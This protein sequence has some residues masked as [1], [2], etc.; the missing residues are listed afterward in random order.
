MSITF[1]GTGTSQG[2]PVIG[3]DCQVCVSSD[4]RDKRLRSSVLVAVNGFQF[5][6]DAG[7]DFRQ[8]MLQNGT[9]RLDAILLTHEHK[10]H[11]AGL[12][13]VRAF[14]YIQQKA[15][16][17]YA[18]PRVCEA[19]KNE[20]QYVFAAKR[21]PGVPQFEL[22]KIGTDAFQIEGQKI[23][24]IRVYHHQLPVLGF[25][26]GDF[27]YLTDLNKIEEDEMKKLKGV[28]LLVVDALRI[29]K[30]ISHYNLEE[31]L[32][33]IQK[34]QVDRAYLTHISHA[35]GNAGQMNA[36]LPNGVS[37]A[38]DGLTIGLEGKGDW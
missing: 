11:I 19:V 13:D 24:P 7:P 26:I 36:Q 33:L 14:N 35:L 3:C 30:H 21:Y 6:I 2:V 5:L 22:H 1:L 25:R 12:D 31:A 28:R 37:L 29:E 16:P 23:V 4:P 15:M 38:Y 10:D 34:V 32:D 20:F 18:E 9:R 8:Q 27:A 17:I